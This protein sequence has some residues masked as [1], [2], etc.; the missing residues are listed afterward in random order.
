VL[1]T[2]VEDIRELVELALLL[3]LQQSHASSPSACTCLL[4]LLVVLEDAASLL[5]L[6]GRCR[7]F[8]SAAM[9]MHGNGTSS[10]RHRHSRRG[11]AAAWEIS[12][13]MNTRAMKIVTPCR[14][15]NKQVTETRQLQGEGTCGRAKT[16]RS[17]NTRAMKIVTPC[18]KSDR[19]ITE[20]QQQQGRM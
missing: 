3:V 17:M 14:K 8:H 4:L 13:S 11:V 16:S 20:A 12:G 18:K 5:L 19:K 6:P 7:A 15:R 2:L 10:S 9:L 1:A